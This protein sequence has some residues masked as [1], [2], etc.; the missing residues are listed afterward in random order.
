MNNRTFIKYGERVGNRTSIEATCT[1]CG[2]TRQFNPLSDSLEQWMKGAL[3]QNAL[4]ELSDDER[5]LFISGTCGACFDL[6]FP[7][8]DDT[9]HS[10]ST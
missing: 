1:S 9:A 4:P 5:E 8:D 3:I 7:G 10:D 6:M 2:I